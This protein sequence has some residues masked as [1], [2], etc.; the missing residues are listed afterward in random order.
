MAFAAVPPVSTRGGG[1]RPRRSKP[2]WLWG[3]RVGSPDRP[4]RRDRQP[5]P[6]PSSSSV[7][8]SASVSSSPL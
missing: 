1:M 2:K 4:F 3:Q 8:S 7:S 5:P 6:P